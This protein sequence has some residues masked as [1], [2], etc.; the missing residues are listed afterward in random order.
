MKAIVFAFALVALSLTAVAGEHPESAK[1]NAAFDKI[2]SLAGSWKGKDEE[3][4][5]VGVS[6]KVVSSNSSVM[7]SLDMKESPDAMITMYNL[8]G[9]KVMMTHYCSMGNQPR[10]RSSGLSKDGNTLN[11]K[12]VDATN[13]ASP[14]D[15]H[16]KNLLVKFKDND[17][18]S[19]EWTM[20]MEGG[21]EHHAVFEFERAK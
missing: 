15:P 8:D 6:Y 13:L 2:K 1:S 4:N 21:T 18:F 17:H 16:M 3:G 20:L 9:D 5:P 19:Q 11:F 10:M 7:E 14:K 12:F